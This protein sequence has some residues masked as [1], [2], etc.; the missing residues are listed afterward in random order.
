[1]RA[2]NRYGEE[3]VARRTAAGLT[4]VRVWA[5][6]MSPAL[7]AR[8]LGENWTNGMAIETYEGFMGVASSG[9]RGHTRP[10]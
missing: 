6:G 7:T 2:G 5:E 10:S 4:S 1:M 3:I 9:E 8:I